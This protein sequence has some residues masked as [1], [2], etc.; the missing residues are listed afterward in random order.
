MQADKKI[1]SDNRLPLVLARAIGAA[2]LTRDCSR[3]ELARFLCAEAA[4]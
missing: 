3:D 1:R 4:R 2:F